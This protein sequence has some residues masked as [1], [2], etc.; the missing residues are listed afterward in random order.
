MDDIRRVESGACCLGAGQSV[1]LMCQQLCSE[2]LH[3]LLLVVSSYCKF[4]GIR[5]KLVLFVHVYFKL[6]VERGEISDWETMGAVGHGSRYVQDV[7]EDEVAVLTVEQPGLD[8][9]ASDAMSRSLGV[10]TENVLIQAPQLDEMGLVRRD[11][12]RWSRL[13]G[14]QVADFMLVVPLGCHEVPQLTMTQPSSSRR[15]G[16]WPAM[17]VGFSLES[18]GNVGGC[19]LFSLASHA[20]LH[21]QKLGLDFIKIQLLVT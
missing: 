3:M 7:F 15:P 5:A 14:P 13:L 12:L 10:V 4:S 9:D 8:C 21:T 20:L 17:L 19:L 16:W 18:S 1:H 11:V 6:E 2:G